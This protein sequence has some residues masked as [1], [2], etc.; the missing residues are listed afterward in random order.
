M[1][2]KIRI[3]A[4]VVDTANLTLYKDNGETVTLKQGDLR[5]RPLLAE[6]TPLLITQG[7]ADVSLEAITPA[8]HYKEFEEQSNGMVKFFRIAKAKLKE[9]FAAEEAPQEPDKPVPQMTIG[10]MPATQHIAT[11]GIYDVS[12][13]DEVEAAHE[14]AYAEP[15]ASATAKTLSAIE[16]ILQ[17]AVPAT[18]QD[19]H[20][21]TV[22]KQ[23][24]I[25]DES[26][27]TDKSTADSTEPDT[28]IAKV[29]DKIIPG[30]EKIK[31]QFIRANKLG[32]HVGVEN[33][34][35][36]LGAVIK[37]RTHSVDDLLKFMERADTPI[38]DDGSI[39][40]YK[41]LKRK[42]DRIDGKYVDCHTKKV[43]QWTGA[44]V[45]MDPSLVDH[46]RNNECSNGLHVARRGY[47]REFSGDVCVLAKLAPEDVIAVPAYDA[48]KMR[49]C[50]YHIL[51]ELTNDQYALLKNNK[52]LTDDEEGKKLLALAL[53]GKH[54]GKTH[55]VKITGQNGTNVVVTALT[56]PVFTKPI[57][58]PKAVVALENPSKEHFDEPVNPKAVIQK[59]E[60]TKLT[61]KEEAAKL[62]EDYKANKAGAL[63]ALLILKKAAKVSWDKLGIPAPDE[64]PTVNVGEKQV[65]VEV[66]IAPT[67]NHK[68]VV[69]GVELGE[70]SSRERIQKMLSIGITSVG[71][72]QA[73]LD[74]KKKSK[75]NWEYLGVPEAQVAIIM[76]LLN[77]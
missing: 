63:E 62:Y 36:R 33:F 39:I 72:A 12:E 64:W 54:I 41:V 17:H 61:R 28:I 49:V 13:A 30:M 2:Q 20:E 53:S 21:E 44:Y 48:N 32:S 26:G 76:K 4:A 19:F 58:E 71:V 37:D 47:I 57:E 11:A 15:K 8:N 67:P 27:Y 9:F 24:D 65:P 38:A 70:G 43:E 14:R 25:T 75:K 16:S 77:K 29:G 46:N 42:G 59:I 18:S 10:T 52:P 1:S 5:I 51:M 3:I 73:I 50:G 55:E 35:K 74:I 23:G 66:V 68:R 7:F 31:T 60:E 22:A 45:C 40:I 56:A 6:V 69:N 34:L